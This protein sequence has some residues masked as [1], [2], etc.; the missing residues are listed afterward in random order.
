MGIELRNTERVEG[1]GFITGRFDAYHRVV[2]HESTQLW[3]HPLSLSRDHE[4]QAGT[5]LGF[6]DLGFDSWTAASSAVLLAAAACLPFSLARERVR[7]SR[8]L[9][10]WLAEDEQRE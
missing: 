9:G 1:F 6:P 2:G 4:A 7:V 5:R 8:F 3:F 10:F